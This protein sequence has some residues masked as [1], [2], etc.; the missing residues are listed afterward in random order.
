MDPGFDDLAYITEAWLDGIGGVS[1]SEVACQLLVSNGS[2]GLM[3]G[4]TGVAMIYMKEITCSR[5]HISPLTS[6]LIL[7]VSI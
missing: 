1:V 2:Q 6:L 4:G 7:N 3:A 5:C